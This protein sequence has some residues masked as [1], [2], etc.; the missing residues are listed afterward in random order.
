MGAAEDGRIGLEFVGVLSIDGVAQRITAA[1][2]CAQDRR[3][4]W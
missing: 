2:E 4:D 1:I 3:N